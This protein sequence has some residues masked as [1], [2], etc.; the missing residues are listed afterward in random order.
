VSTSETGA[1]GSEQLLTDAG[2]A[3]A[4]GAFVGAVGEDVPLRRLARGHLFPVAAT[5][6]LQRRAGENMDVH[7]RLF[8]NNGARL[9]SSMIS[10]ITA[11]GTAS[12]LKPL[13]LRRLCTSS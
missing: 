8:I 12:F 5:D 4:M 6:L 1:H 10:R 11:F 9:A 7:G 3:L 2:L 13:T